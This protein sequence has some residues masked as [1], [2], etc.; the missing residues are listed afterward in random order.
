MPRVA[1]VPDI[2]SCLLYHEVYQGAKA[3]LPFYRRLCPSCDG[4]YFLSFVY[5]AEAGHAVLGL[6]I[7]S[8]KQEHVHAVAATFLKE[9]GQGD[10]L[11]PSQRPPDGPCQ[12][13]RRAHWTSSPAVAVYSPCSHQHDYLRSRCVLRPIIVISGWFHGGHQPSWASTR[14]GTLRLATM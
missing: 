1:C 8:C 2:L 9:K 7:H 5:S 10:T 14:V 3:L 4:S 13:G 12:R 6:G 11:T